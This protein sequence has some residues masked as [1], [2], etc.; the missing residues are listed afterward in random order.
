[1]IK[2]A[3]LLA[4]GDGFINSHTANAVSEEI[5]RIF[6]LG[7]E[8]LRVFENLEHKKTACYRTDGFYQTFLNSIVKRIPLLSSIAVN[9]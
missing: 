6:E 1:M 9:L 4:N 2:P 8:Q 7:S 5:R 3:R